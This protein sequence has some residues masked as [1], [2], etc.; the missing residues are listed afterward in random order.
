[1]N[2]GYLMTFPGWYPKLIESGRLLF[3]THAEFSPSEGGENMAVY[4]WEGD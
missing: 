4:T 2:A 1:V 3:T